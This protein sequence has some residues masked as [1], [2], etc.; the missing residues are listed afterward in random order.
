VWTAPKQAKRI[1][2]LEAEVADLKRR[3]T[4]PAEYV[5]AE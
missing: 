5:K 4:P 2:E 1:A 3:L